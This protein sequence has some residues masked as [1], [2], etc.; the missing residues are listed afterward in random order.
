M[1]YKIN[2]ISTARTGC[3]FYITLDIKVIIIQHMY[4]TPQNKEDVVSE[5]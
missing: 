5:R 4:I 3:I 1:E 2:G